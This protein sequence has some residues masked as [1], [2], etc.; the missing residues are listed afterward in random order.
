MSEAR[1]YSPARLA[2]SVACA[3]GVAAAAMLAVGYLFNRVEA[4]IPGIAAEYAQ[5]PGFRPWPGWTER[6]ML[7]HPIWFGF[8]FAAGFVVWS[9]G[10]NAATWQAACCRGASYGGLLF[11]VGSMPVFALIYA[12]F[13][14]SP[15]LIAV[16]WAGRNF[17]QYVVAGMCVGMALWVRQWS[18]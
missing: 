6:Y 12:S 4:T 10:Q 8:V 16:S 13:Q 18:R 3:G 5:S 1:P 15:Q 9:R 7:L 17:A 11:L 2:V 14:V